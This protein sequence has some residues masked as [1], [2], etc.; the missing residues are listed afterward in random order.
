MSRL[1]REQ[2]KNPAEDDGGCTARVALKIE[3]ALSRT[4]VEYRLASSLADAPGEVQ[5]ATVENGGRRLICKGILVMGN[6]VRAEDR[7]RRQAVGTIRKS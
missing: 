5:S 7:V 1:R 4:M 2:T 6:S 3:T